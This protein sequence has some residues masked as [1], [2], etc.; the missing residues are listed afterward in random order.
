MGVTMRRRDFLGLA[1]AGSASVSMAAAAGKHGQA[2]RQGLG[3]VVVVGAGYGGATAAR[4]LRLL[5]G[6]RIDV[7]LVDR[8]ADFVSCPVS[9]RVLGGRKTLEQLTFGYDAL[10]KNHGVKFMQGSVTAID[11]DK[12]TIA[13]A[14]T[15]L[16]Y[17]RLIVAPGI[18]F[19]YDAFPGLAGAQQQIPHAWKAG[20]QTRRRPTSAPARS[21]F[22]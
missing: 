10:R 22:T 12:S 21:R 9:N 11:A 4:H 18:D 8:N 1:L 20:P 13:V 19:I 14:G 2:R 17:D 3:R 7:I 5:S 16:S 6:G 15:K